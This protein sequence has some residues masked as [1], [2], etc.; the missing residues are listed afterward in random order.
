MELEGLVLDQDESSPPRSR[1][2]QPTW[3]RRSPAHVDEGESSLTVPGGKT[4]QKSKP[5]IL[6]YS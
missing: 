1:A 4:A 5:N 6:A 2:I 3:R